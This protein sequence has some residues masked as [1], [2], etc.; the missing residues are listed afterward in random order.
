V[1]LTE[2]VAVLDARLLE[3]SDINRELVEKA[4]TAKRLLGGA[5]TPQTKSLVVTKTA[6]IP[7]GT[8]VATL[9]RRMTHLRQ[10]AMAW[11]HETG[12]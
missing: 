9:G 10:A 5:L 11:E 6:V 8:S 3:G 7:S 2:V 12:R 4:R 1:R